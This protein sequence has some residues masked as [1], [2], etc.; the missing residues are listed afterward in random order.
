VT[1]VTEAEWST[2]KGDPGIM[3]GFLKER[4]WCSERKG[5]LFQHAC[6]RRVFHLFT[7]FQRR[8]V[9]LIEEREEGTPLGEE[10]EGLQEPT[11]GHPWFEALWIE[12]RAARDDLNG[13][14]ACCGLLRCIFANPF[15]PVALDPTWLSSTVKALA[16]S[17]YTDRNFEVMPILAD[18]LEEAGCSSEDILS[19]CRGP[20]EHV[21][22][23]WAVDLLLGK[24]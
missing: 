9:E 17:I 12:S 1:D 18:A 3:L 5:R 23:C 8:A 22:G 16:Q 20:G 13:Q 24:E 6:L 7:D 4:G 21:R 2:Y 14:S 11:G 10:W 19:H 15:R